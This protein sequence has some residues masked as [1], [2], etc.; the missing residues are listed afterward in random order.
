MVEKLKAFIGG[1]SQDTTNESL[2]AYFG[3][4]GSADSFVMMDKGT[5]RSRGFGF[6][7]FQD[8]MV[9]ARV[10][11]L[12]H[13][14]DGSPITIRLYQAP[15]EKGGGGSTSFSA[16]G[17]GP[18]PRSSSRGKGAPVD[19]GGSR[20]F[21]PAPMGR[22]PWD[23]Q[24]VVAARDQLKVFVGG[25]GQ[26]TSKESLDAHFGQF[27]YADSFIMI[28]KG[29]GRSRGFGFVNFHD[30]DVLS[31]VLQMPHHEI[32]GVVVS[33]SAYTG[34]S[35]K[36]PPPP[37]RGLSG[38]GR[39]VEAPAAS[40]PWAR[41]QRGG[42]A[43]APSR[44]PAQ[45]GEAAQLAQ[46][47]KQPELAHLLQKVQAQANELIVQQGGN[48][49]V[50]SLMGGGGG[51]SGS[52]GGPQSHLKVFVGGIGQHTTKESLNEY[53]S[54]FGRVDSIIMMDKQSGRSRGF[55]FVD[56]QDEETMEAALSMTHEVDG[57]K[58]SISAYADRGQPGPPQ[59]QP[60]QAP[61]GRGE[62]SAA[63]ANII[64]STVEM[65]AK[66]QAGFGGRQGDGGQPRAMPEPE[67]KPSKLFIT[68]LD[69]H[70]TAE[71]LSDAFSQYGDC[72]CEVV[73]DKQSSR[74]RG[75][76]FVQYFSQ[77][78]ST[79]AAEAADHF[80]NG[81]RV[82]VSECFGAGSSSKTSASRSAR[83]APY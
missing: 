53:F 40:A 24:P 49:A 69:Q 31:A 27:G 59:R 78:D 23:Q 82:E 54:Q 3:Q 35:G 62:V 11:E 45:A 63:A 79:A 20:D 58:V 8:E 10:L 12:T 32:D 72:E 51:S 1:L 6:V 2:N 36:G 52:R 38:K 43:T 76:G 41:G 5:G 15:A 61:G 80:V 19:R 37:Q 34:G 67:A 68:G 66:L 17:G 29:T 60:R 64:N 48:P 22:A 74:S 56:F 55:G 50:Q 46:I 70:I 25:L 26:D 4:F 9:L 21:G 47:L 13:S 81:R 65:V 28:D 75:F 42:G 30:E 83:S 57:V 18:A 73:V 7:N 71:M 39:Q 14:V 77:G 44:T 33:V 16:F